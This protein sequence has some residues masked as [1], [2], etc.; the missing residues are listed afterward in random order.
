M[1][2]I[3]SFT[4]TLLLYGTVRY[5]WVAIIICCLSMEP[6]FLGFVF[7]LLPIQYRY[8]YRIQIRSTQ[9]S[10]VRH[11]SLRSV[12]A[13]IAMSYSTVTF[14]C[15]SQ[16]SCNFDHHDQSY[17][18]Y[19]PIVRRTD[20]MIHTIRRRTVL[21]VQIPTTPGFSLPYPVHNRA[22]SAR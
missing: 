13:P 19:N 2:G 12:H 4:S 22:L 20:R 18:P 11:K 6:T 15:L 21:L 3:D 7:D 16:T 1:E 5:V 8:E 9:P 17:K 14:N 10:P